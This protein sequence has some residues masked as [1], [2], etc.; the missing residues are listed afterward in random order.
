[1]KHPHAEVLAAWLADTSLKLEYRM[2][3]TEHWL[4]PNTKT[5]NPLTRY[6]FEWRIAPKILSINGREFPAPRANNSGWYL[7]IQTGTGVKNFYHDTEEARDAHYKALVLASGG[8][9]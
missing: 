2:L 9:L 4:T 6:D 3:S 5:T 7:K 1:M 8:V